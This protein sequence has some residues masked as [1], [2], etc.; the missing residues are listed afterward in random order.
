M[1]QGREL[2]LLHRAEGKLPK[3]SPAWAL[4]QETWPRDLHFHSFWRGDG[5]GGNAMTNIAIHV[6]LSHRAAQFSSPS[7]CQLSQGMCYSPAAPP[8]WFPQA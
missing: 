6:L 3:L 7:C 1:G 2:I 8:A 5:A 4:S